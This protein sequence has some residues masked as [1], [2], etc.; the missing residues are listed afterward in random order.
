[1]RT[2]GVLSTAEQLMADY[3]KAIENRQALP[4]SLP[5]RLFALLCNEC[6]LIQF[7]ELKQRFKA[8][9]LKVKYVTLCQVIAC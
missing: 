4:W 1:M 7:L 2:I 6:K 8:S 9:N 5:K 3:N